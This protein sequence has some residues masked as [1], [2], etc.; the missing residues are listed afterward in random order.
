M[1]TKNFLNLSTG[2]QTAYQPF[3]RRP[4]RTEDADPGEY[5]A[6]IAACYLSDFLYPRSY[7]SAEFVGVPELARQHPESI[8]VTRK[9]DMHYQ[10]VLD[11]W[12][13]SPSSQGYGAPRKAWFT[14]DPDFDTEIATRFGETID[15]ALAGGL[16]EWDTDGPLGTLARIIVLDQ[17]TRNAFRGTAKSFSGDGLALEAAQQL[18]TSGAHLNL[19]ALERWFAY[20]PFEHAEDLNMQDLSVALFTKLADDYPGFDEVLG[21]VRKYRDVIA[22]FGRFPFRNSMLGRASTPQEISFLSQLG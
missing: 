9:E 16:C 18:R 7:W 21:W 6:K 14:A 17:F 1:Q 15:Q 13:G 12:Y 22:R 19:R 10:H 11:F 8:S 5:S 20:M 2:Q 4:N 3:V